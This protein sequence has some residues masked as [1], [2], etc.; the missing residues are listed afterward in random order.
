M[1]R[2]KHLARRRPNG[3]ALPSGVST[4]KL[5]EEIRVKRKPKRRERALL[6][7]RRF[8]GA[9]GNTIASVDSRRNLV[10]R[11]PFIRLV[12][13][14]S[15]SSAGKSFRFTREA[16]DCIQQASEAYLTQIFKN[17][18][19]IMAAA[20]KQTLMQQHLKAAI[21]IM[22]GGTGAW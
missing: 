11:A 9:V 18:V 12:R 17:S 20:G 19:L 8:Q 16:L 6:E 13:E 14:I 1:A 5:T 3:A 22:S 7:I 15:F 10:P 2:M 21:R 4:S